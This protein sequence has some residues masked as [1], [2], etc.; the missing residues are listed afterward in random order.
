MTVR[1]RK[2]AFWQ[3]REWRLL[4]PFYLEGGVSTIFYVFVPF[5]VLYFRSLGMNASEI[6]FLMSAWPLSALLLE[7][8]TG[9]IADL[10]GRK[11]SV[12]LG[13]CAEGIFAALLFFFDS[14]AAVY[15]LFFLIGSARTLASGAQEAWAVDLLSE[16]E[17]GCGDLRSRYFSRYHS[18]FNLA[19]VLSGLAGAGCVY[20][21]NLRAIWL[22]TAFSYFLSAGFLAFAREN[23]EPARATFRGALK[24]VW[25]QT[26]QTAGFARRNHTVALI[27]SISFLIAM[28]GIFRSMITWTPFLESYGFPEEGFG[29]LWSAMNVFGIV[30]PLLAYRMV[31]HTRLRI[32]LIWLSVI[33]LIYGF[34]ILAT[35]S[36]VMLLGLILVSAFIFDFRMPITRV[37][38]HRFIPTRIRSTS[39]SFE[40][41]LNSGARLVSF[42]LVGVLIDTIGARYTVFISTLFMVPVIGL[43]LKIRE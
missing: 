13:Y 16:E 25:R 7:V 32:A 36:M 33:T 27:Y 19:F 3:S 22:V 6:G 37:F 10:W 35:G 40:Q 26:V 4:W 24:G 39:G 17:E 23:F 14:D 42:P 18:L 31:R 21:W 11:I 12:L 15:I 8:P 2:P 30:A 5:L 34:F 20:F 41:M 38:F 1:R 29:Y 9:A 43:Y 28:S